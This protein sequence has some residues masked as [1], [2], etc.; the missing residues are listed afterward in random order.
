VSQQQLARSIWLSITMMAMSTLMLIAAV[1]SLI[2]HAPAVGET[3]LAFMIIFGVAGFT[4]SV[5]SRYRARSFAQARRD[6]R[7]ADLD[8]TFRRSLP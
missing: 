8:E 5:I 7:R 1:L 3:F 2:A 4:S 6:E